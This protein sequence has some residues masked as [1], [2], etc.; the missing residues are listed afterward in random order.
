MTTIREVLGTL[1]LRA[2]ILKHTV[3]VV[4]MV[5]QVLAVLIRG[6]ALSIFPVV[7]LLPKVAP[8]QTV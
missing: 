8:V 7:V 5:A 2:V 3:V 6:M 4:A 1:P